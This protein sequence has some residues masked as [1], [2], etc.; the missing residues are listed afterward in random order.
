MIVEISVMLI[1]LHRLRY[2][3]INRYFDL[4]C[5]FVRRNR[6]GMPLFL[7][8]VV[9]FVDDEDFLLVYTN[10]GENRRDEQQRG[11]GYGVVRFKKSTKEGAAP[12]AGWLVTFKMRDN[13]GREVVGRLPALEREG[14]VQVIKKGAKKQEEVLYTVRVEKGFEPPVY[15][16]GFYLVKRGEDGPDEELGVFEVE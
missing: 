12:Y 3:G 9:G 6:G 4:W 15:A 7:W 8:G 1:F 14:V 10:P 2:T 16:K 5:T 13:D 11:D